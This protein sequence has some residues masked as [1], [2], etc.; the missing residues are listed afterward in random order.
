MV[1]SLK[2]R[3]A[4]VLAVSMITTT[5]PQ[6]IL[7]KDYTGHWAAQAI[8]K[9]EEKGIIKGY[10]DGTFKP[11]NTVTRAE[12]AQ[13][14]VRVFGYTDTAK[15]KSYGDVQAGAWY[16]D[17]VNRIS[18]AGVMYEDG[19]NFR[20]NDAITREEA[21]YALAQAYKVQGDS[22]R[23]FLDENKIS[24]WA[25][26]QIRAMV[27][28]GY[29]NGT[30]EGNVEPQKT[31]T[32]AE[33]VTILDNMTQNIIS[34]A[35]TYTENVEGNL[36]VNTRDVVLKDM[37]IEGNL[38]LGEGIGDGDVTLENIEVKGE[39]IVEGGGINSIK[40][41]NSKYH[42]KF[43]VSAENPVRVVI[44]GDAV[45]VEA[46]P[47]TNV[48][49]TGSFS[50]VIVA[51]NVNMTV[52]DATV[53]TIIAA[54]AT[55]PNEKVEAPIINIEGSAKV[56]T[57]QADAP[58][59]VKG[60]GKVE[61]LVVNTE[62]VKI[63]QTPTHV[64]IGKNQDKDLTVNIGG[65]DET[66]DTIDKNNKPE[67]PSTD[68]NNGNNN[69]GN[70][71]DNN[72]NNGN[73]NGH[74]CDVNKKVQI[75]GQVRFENEG[76]G[77]ATVKIT[78]RKEDNYVV[79]GTTDEEGYY[80]FF[81][82]A[83]ELYNIEA[84]L[85]DEDGYGYHVKNR[86]I[87]K[88]HE[89]KTVNL[90][91][92]KRHVVNFK[93]VDKNDVPVRNIEIVP[94]VNGKQDGW[95]YTDN[96]G[97]ATRYLW[98]EEAK[99]GFEF[100]ANGKLVYSIPESI[101]ADEAYKKD[102]YIKL[103]TIGL[104]NTIEGQVLNEADNKPLA[105]TKVYLYELI[106]NGP[107]SSSTY[108]VATTI[109]DEKGFYSFNIPDVKKTYLVEVH[110]KTE[111]GNYYASQDVDARFTAH[112]GLLVKQAYGV[113]ITVVD[114]NDVPM[115]WV[116]VGLEY[117]QGGHSYTNTNSDGSK[118]I[119]GYHIE[120]GLHVVKA[121]I[122]DDVKVHGLQ[123]VEGKYNYEV[124]FKYDNIVE[125]RRIANISIDE[126]SIQVGDITIPIHSVRMIGVNEANNPDAGSWGVGNEVI[127][128]KATLVIPEDCKGDKVTLEV[129]G[130]NDE[131]L[132]TKE[133]VSFTEAILNYNINLKDLPRHTLTGQVLL[134]GE[135][136]TGAAITINMVGHG[137]EDTTVG[138]TDT[139]ANLYTQENLVEGRYLVRA[140][141]TTGSALYVATSRVDVDADTN[142]DMELKE[143]RTIKVKVEDEAGNA[144][145]NTGVEINFMG[146]NGE[147]V[148]YTVRTND[149]G[150]LEIIEGLE[151]GQEI[152]FWVRRDNGI[153]YETLQDNF[154]IEDG[155]NSFKVIA[156]QKEDRM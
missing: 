32:R 85:E 114:K 65:K 51:P 44:E 26:A 109:T 66:K 128:G 83:C 48:T 121:M 68:S 15:A 45:K 92:I 142:L 58:V 18:D 151:V 94:M 9:W 30:P 132:Y 118:D 116:R 29:I 2:K 86:N 60:E 137:Y 76:V 34:V 117:P 10:E 7:A 89:S 112:T 133:N 78:T 56:E 87:P 21:A 102:M 23:V 152:W 127:N 53:E 47:G 4:L 97:E 12:F 111:E 42:E 88:V 3:L 136:T 74:I 70:N 147:H 16:F 64:E 46:M 93:V 96:F 120:P 145:T 105:N 35:G 43:I 71:N 90:D 91:L 108:D 5:V 122:E 119:F 41:K 14:L 27:A 155:D 125:N 99:Y 84:W 100:Y 130:Q 50:D 37:I 103:D 63:Q 40:S 131:I 69:N 52:K 80:S 95:S 28:N 113:K 73:N 134:N 79:H 59:E 39:V 22:E 98:D 123:I 8:A 24:D 33:L 138:K 82:P 154:K 54:P 1:K 57:V 140:E 31:L 17:A 62:G 124:V 6:M 150:E 144:I 115:P 141:V 101:Q 72:S 110:T 139:K 149:K 49:L 67:K 156:K 81:V 38:Y 148:Y 153:S 143:A 25:K 126:K 77:Y 106:A 104:D 75:K 20:P 107:D 11:K 19:E 13:I 135:V 129:L 55:N 146:N 36:V 61:N